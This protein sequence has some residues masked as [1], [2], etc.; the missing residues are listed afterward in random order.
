MGTRPYDRAMA[1]IAGRAESELRPAGPGIRLEMPTDGGRSGIAVITIDRPERRNAVDLVALSALRA[2]QMTLARTESVRCAVIT[3]T[4]P[5]F[6]AGADL[7]GVRDE[8]FADVLQAVLS[9]F[10][11]LPIPVIAAID[12]P[13]LG[14]GTQIAM[15]CDL[16][17]ATPASRFGIPAARLGLVIDQRTVDRLVREVGWPMARAMLLAAEVVDA[18]R[19]HALGAVHRLGD[20]ESALAWAAEI[21]ELAP[22]SIAGH[23]LALERNTPHG[24]DGPADAE[25]ERAR[26]AALAS[27]DADE[28]RRAFLD[29]RPAR[30]TGG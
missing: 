13:A 9:G 20:L 16:R 10:T 22:L 8:E 24:P 2:A 27:A 7:R 5:G 19:L 4:P 6:C 21:A 25:V 28:G 14:A 15:A 17:V 1:D 11:E 26:S 18:E 3:G 23:K 29:K 12:G 30:F